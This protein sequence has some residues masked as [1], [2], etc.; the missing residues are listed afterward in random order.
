MKLYYE[1]N[2]LPLP[3]NSFLYASDEDMRW[4]K[5]ARFGLFVHWGPGSLTGGDLSWCRI[6]DRPGDH[7]FVADPKVPAC[8]Y[9]MLYKRF[10]PVLFDAGEWVKTIKLAGMKYI[11]V[12]AKHHDGFCLFD[13]RFTDYKSTADDCPCGKDIVREL[14]DACH[15]AGIK[16]GVYYS[17]RDWYH[18]D[19]LKGDNSKYLAYYTAQ[20]AEL[21]TGYGKIDLLWFDHIGGEHK[22]W[23]PD[24]ILR[25]A[26]T[27]Q[28]G[29]IINDR[30][31]RSVHHG[32]LAGYEADFSSPEQR[33][34]NFDNSRAWESCMCLVD[35][36]W[37]Y[38]PGGKIMSFAECIR[39]LVSCAGGDGN[40]LLNTGPMPDGRIEPRQCDR[41]GEI[42]SWLKKYG[43]SIYATRGGPVLPTED[44]V[45]TCRG[46]V[47]YLHILNPGSY[48]ITGIP[49]NVKEIIVLSGT[50]SVNV[51]KE[52]MVI[53]NAD[54]GIDCDAII[55][56][57]TD[58]EYYKNN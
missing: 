15:R 17:G 14:S 45:C 31:H 47:Y 50:A 25:L 39:A 40:L 4:W 27:L 22:L 49:G 13:S 54:G 38:R 2:G 5:E 3:V 33:V 23:N 16:F 7:T 44:Y 37:A 11:V 26:R 10:N 30:L 48:D 24:T 12:V 57:T 19:Y 18:P 52:S 46:N 20:V 32:A 1:N 53:K 56:V 8:D 41:L 34:G 42:G 28:P 55:R 51:F 9:D 36:V 29:I 21:L 58:Q 43:E 35:G 6:S